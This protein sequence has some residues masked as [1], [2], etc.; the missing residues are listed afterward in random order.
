MRATQGQR[1]MIAAEVSNLE[2]WDDE[3]RSIT[4]SQKAMA[5][6]ILFPVAPTAAERGAKGGRGNKAAAVSAGAFG[7]TLLRHARAVIAY[8]PPGP[9]RIRLRLAVSWVWPP[10]AFN[11]F[12]SRR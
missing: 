3:R 1:A 6:A 8:A 9:R 11:S 10:L 4:T 12:G 7:D 2:N 5:H